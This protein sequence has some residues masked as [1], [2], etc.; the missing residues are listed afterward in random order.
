MQPMLE[1]LGAKKFVHQ[2]RGQSTFQSATKMMHATR[3]IES[4]GTM[5][6]MY[7][8]S[9]QDLKRRRHSVRHCTANLSLAP[10]EAE[11]N[12]HHSRPRQVKV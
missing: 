2:G 12:R 1:G 5:S 3:D 7:Q 6:K 4:T 10:R 8:A 9:A 11:K